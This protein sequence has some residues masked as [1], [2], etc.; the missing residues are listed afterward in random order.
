MRELK[1]RDSVVLAHAMRGEVVDN[2]YRGCV[3]VVDTGGDVRFALGD[4]EY[5][6]FIR[7]AGKPLQ[8][9]ALVELGGVEAYD[10]DDA[11][12][13]I[14]CAS[15]SGKALQVQTVR[16]LLG[17]IGVAESSLRAGSGITDNCSGKHAGMLALAKLQGHHIDG[18]M[19]RDHPIQTVI[20]ERVSELCGLPPAEVEVATDGCG[21]PI[22]A[23][24][25]RN[26]AL[27]YARLANVGDLP[28]ARAQAIERIARA[29]RRHPEMVGGLDFDAICSAEVVAKSGAAGCHC[30]GF[31]GKQA[32]LAI[33]VA[34]G[35]PAATL[36]VM[37]EVARR[38]GLIEEAD[39]ARF[40]E[41][42][43]PLV[44][45]RRGQVVGEVRIVF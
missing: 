19:E 18:Y 4:P 41:A 7:S 30:I 36:P 43:P 28:P 32:G 16:R 33:K 10:M 5:R 29:M 23:M 20:L 6:A 22:F 12:L 15:H 21:A 39:F 24:P 2:V 3:A 45:N 40:T 9:L 8:A 37:F 1:M 27:G 34:D 14:I 42:C 13:A 25:L 26:M 11:E 44:K 35:S 38:Q 17:K 31:C